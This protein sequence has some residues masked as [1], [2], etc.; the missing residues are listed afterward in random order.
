M[1]KETRSKHGTRSRYVMGCRCE[2]CRAANAADRAARIVRRPL[3]PVEPVVEHLRALQAAGMSRMRIAKA[4]RVGEATLDRIVRQPGT[5]MRGKAA[6]AVLGVRAPRV[7][8]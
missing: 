8:P 6:R 4:A 2:E 7:A 5:R 1:A 3:V